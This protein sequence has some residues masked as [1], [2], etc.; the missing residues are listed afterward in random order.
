MNR[1]S[2]WL[3]I[4]AGI[5]AAGS[6]SLKA[7]AADAKKGTVV[8]LGSLK[9][10][11]PADWKEVETQGQFRTNQFKIPKVNGDKA[12]ADLIVFFFGKGG[13]GSI[14]QNV[15]RWKGMF[16]PP[17]GKEIDDVAKVEKFKV[18]DVEVTYL[19]VAGTYK[20]KARPFDPNAKEELRPDHRM[21]AV[22]FGSDE[23][24]FYIRLVGPAKTVGDHKKG[25]DEWLKAFK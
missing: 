5:L 23:G 17:D 24:P 8:S 20:F 11:A 15:K 9:S 1:T 12:D 14:D 18:G 22:Y 7:N 3:A 16:A 6:L 19:D 2:W 25:F 21:I 13:G 4:A 10:T